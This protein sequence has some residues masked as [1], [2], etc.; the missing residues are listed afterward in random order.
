MTR[1]SKQFPFDANYDFEFRPESYWP[2]LP[3]E[4][5]FVSK[6]RGTARRQIAERSLA[7]EELERIGDDDLY[8]EAMEFV[9]EEELPEPDREGWGRVHPQLMGG[10]YLPKMEGDEVE[11]ARIDLES[12][13][14]DAIDVRARR[15][16]GPI[17][18][19]IVDEYETVFEISP[20]VSAE[21]LTLGEL[22]ELI[23]TAA[24][25]G[26]ESRGLTDFY[27]DLNLDGVDAPEELL[28]FVTVSSAFYP[29]LGRYYDDR[30]RAWVEETKRESES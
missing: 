9:L 18:Y 22:I 25:S 27:L 24:D 29:Q 4:K 14:A 28:G 6:I 11:I 20:T 1:P 17:H 19:R 7:G 23:D 3:G 8:R 10:E 30:S 2:D 21:P 5:G 13:T 16:D 12:V 15:E 26:G